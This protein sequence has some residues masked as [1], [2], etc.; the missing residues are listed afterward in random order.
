MLY[1]RYRGGDTSMRGFKRFQRRSMHTVEVLV[2]VAKKSIDLQN[3]Q[4]SLGLS[5]L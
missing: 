1:N 3:E 2:N 5:Q 4:V